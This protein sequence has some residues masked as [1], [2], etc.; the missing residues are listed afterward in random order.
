MRREDVLM[1]KERLDPILSRALDNPDSVVSCS[2]ST[3]PSDE[4]GERCELGF[5][6][7][8]SLRFNTVEIKL[9]RVIPINQKEC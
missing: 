9:T 1:L 2:V 8:Y 6:C 3:Y 7:D 5:W 4:N